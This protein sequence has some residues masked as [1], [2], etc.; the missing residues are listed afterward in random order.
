MSI[1]QRR[2]VKRKSYPDGGEGE[3]E[4]DESKAEGRPQRLR[5]RISRI[6]EDGGRI[7]GDDVD[8]THLRTCERKA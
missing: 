6:R 7:E 5:R 1:A 2:D 8:T 4:V 3:D